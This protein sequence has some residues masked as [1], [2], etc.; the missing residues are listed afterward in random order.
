MLSINGNEIKMTRGDTVV[1][2]MTIYTPEGKVYELNSGDKLYFTVKTLPKDEKTPPLI[3][4]VFTC[5]DI[6]L[7]P[8]DTQFLK[9]GRYFWDSTLEFADGSINTVASGWLTLGYEVR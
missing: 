5:N 3:E 8:I 9:Y 7:E 1:L 4:K 6:T 2:N